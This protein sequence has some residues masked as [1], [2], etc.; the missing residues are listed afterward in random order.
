VE[1]TS[2]EPSTYSWTGGA[3]ARTSRPTYERLT[4]VLQTADAGR[5]ADAC[6]SV[7]ELLNEQVDRNSAANLDDVIFTSAVARRLTGAVPPTVNLYLR[8]YE[9]PQISLFNLLARHL[10]TVSLAGRV[11]NELVCQFVA[12]LD[13]FTLLDVG[14]G[15]AQQ[16]VALLHKLAR[17]G[18]L[19]RRLTVIAVEPSGES[20]RAAERALRD[21]AG[22]LGVALTIRAVLAVAEELTDA[23]WARI[24]ATPQPMV[25]LSSFAA[26]HVRDQARA[27]GVSACARDALF[28]RLR[29]LDPRA[30]ILCEPNADHHTPSFR[31]RF[32]SC[33]NHFGLTFDLIGRLDIGEDEKA[34]MKMFFARE[35]EDILAN[36]EESRC[37]RHEPVNVW[38]DRLE[39]TGFTPYD[40]LGFV[41]GYA[42]PLVRV[43]A[44]RGYVG[45]DHGDE[46][47]VA[48]LCATTG[49]RPAGAGGDA[50]RS[51]FHGSAD[52]PAA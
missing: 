52:R 46:T 24:A 16:E 28:S 15:T 49:A 3:P 50:E 19:P 41:R 11:A 44:K 18:A 32:D 22:Q 51:L 20:L 1:R 36:A 31:R 29:A 14:I 5:H 45:L 37:E 25:V 12:G 9:R 39:R 40:R 43:S 27:D 8:Q 23:D 2:F 38:A 10:P 30:V 42:D 26:H 47:L 33:W 34:A 7:G 48:V 6:E 13:E 17:R 35:I 21:A 4:A